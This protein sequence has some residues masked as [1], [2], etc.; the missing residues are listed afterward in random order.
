MKALMIMMMATGLTCA[1][2]RADDTPDCK[3]PQDQLTLTQCAGLDYEKADTDLN[4]LW[5]SVKASAE[6][7]DKSASPNEGGYK[8]ALL[9]SQKAWIVFRDAECTWAGFE[10]HGGSMEPMLVNGC[11]ARLTRERIKQLK[12]NEESVA[13]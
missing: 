4:A 2:A 6:E 12:S 5:P 13:Q 9:A 10:A 8:Q 3:D 11:L 1:E 7:Q